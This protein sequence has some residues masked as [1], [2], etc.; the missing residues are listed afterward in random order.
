M[1]THLATCC[2]LVGRLAADNEP[3]ARLCMVKNAARAGDVNE[4]AVVDKLEAEPQVHI[5]PVKYK[6]TRGSFSGRPT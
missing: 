5:T 4:G 3:P 1:L 2:A 6:G